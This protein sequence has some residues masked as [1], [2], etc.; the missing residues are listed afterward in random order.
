MYD[1]ARSAEEYMG[2][3]LPG[4]TMPGYTVRHPASALPYTLSPAARAAGDPSRHGTCLWSCSAPASGLRPSAILYILTRLV[5][6]SSVLRSRQSTKGNPLYLQGVSYT[7]T[8]LRR[9]GVPVSVPDQLSLD[10]VEARAE[11]RSR[12]GRG[13]SRGLV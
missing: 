10:L 13:Q 5:S 12:P 6:D 3:T 8:S 2:C 1:E 9:V 11:A 4:Y 7:E